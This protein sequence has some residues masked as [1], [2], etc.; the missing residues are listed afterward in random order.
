M[1]IKCRVY[2]NKN[3]NGHHIRGIGD[4]FKT[5]VKKGN[6]KCGEILVLI[7]ESEYVDLLEKHDKRDIDNETRIKEIEETARIIAYRIEREGEIRR[8]KE[9]KRLARREK[10]EYLWR[11]HYQHQEK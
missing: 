5:L 2:K 9:E 4:T 11:G 10:V 7:K 3:A 6:F 8:E 1:I